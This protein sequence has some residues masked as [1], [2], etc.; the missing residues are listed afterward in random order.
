MPAQMGI[1]ISMVVIKCVSQSIDILK[2]EN[3]KSGSPRKGSALLVEP[4][5]GL[6]FDRGVDAITLATTGNLQE[7]SAL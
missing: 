5:D 7:L 1:P 2:T 3:K 6:E 4:I